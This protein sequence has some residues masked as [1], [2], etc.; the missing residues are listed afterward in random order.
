MDPIF[1]AIPTRVVFEAPPDV[2]TPFVIIQVPGGFSLSGDG[3]AWSPLIQ[4]D[5]YCAITYPDARK[6]VWTLAAEAAR[7]LG[8][9]R[10]ITFET[11]SYSARLVDG[12]LED[13]DLSRGTA[14]PLR[15]ALIRAA[16]AVHTT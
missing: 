12:P 4:V 9:A 15:R 8:R 3:V 2:T 10:N 5:G 13:V 7:I 14:N 16:L 11:M 1:A 6:Q